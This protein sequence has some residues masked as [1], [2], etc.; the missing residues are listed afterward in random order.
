MLSNIFWKTYPYSNTR[1]TSCRGSKCENVFPVGSEKSKDKRRHAKGHQGPGTGEGGCRARATSFFG[2][3]K[4][5]SILTV[6]KD[7][8][9]KS[10]LR[11]SLVPF[12]TLLKI[13][14]FFFNREW[15]VKSPFK[16]FESEE[17]HL[18]GKSTR[19]SPFKSKENLRTKI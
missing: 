5:R 4:K 16:K 8:R 19:N 11:S 12:T 2:N 17:T 13:V 1:S 6:W 14:S 9:Q 3:H 18:N 10:K 7:T 15:S